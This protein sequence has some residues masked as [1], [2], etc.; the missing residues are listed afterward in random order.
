M[1]GTRWWS[2]ISVMFM[3]MISW[4]LP[5]L[6]G[7]QGWVPWDMPM[8][9]G[10]W[11]MV[12]MIMMFIFWAAVMIAIVFLI[13]WLISSSGSGQRSE[14]ARDTDSAL[15]ILQKRYARGEISKQDYEDMRRDMMP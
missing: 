5:S 7:G 2:S 6:A 12:M 14:R 3:L 11:G 9:R 15:E 4:G 8:M 10:G 1:H 13:R